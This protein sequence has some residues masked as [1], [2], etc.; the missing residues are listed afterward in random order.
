M[1]A[2]AAAR[3]A[4]PQY[5]RVA[6]DLLHGIGAGTFPVG[7]LLPTEAELCRR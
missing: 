5:T 7:S 1:S 2:I 6:R 3:G 4:T